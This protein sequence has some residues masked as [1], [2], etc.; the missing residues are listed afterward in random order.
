MRISNQFRSDTY[1]GE[2]RDVEIDAT[3]L[4]NLVIFP[5]DNAFSICVNVCVLYMWLNCVSES[6]SDDILYHLRRSTI[7]IPVTCDSSESL[8]IYTDVN[9]EI[10]VLPFRHKRAQS[11][12]QMAYS[13]VFFWNWKNIFLW[14]NEP[15]IL[16]DCVQGKFICSL[17]SSGTLSQRGK[18]YVSKHF[19]FK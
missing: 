19:P 1:A 17:C 12:W 2:N 11:I 15:D 7:S 9:T 5:N 8:G 4:P 6:C 10:Q 16:W 3:L 13:C 14:I 18:N